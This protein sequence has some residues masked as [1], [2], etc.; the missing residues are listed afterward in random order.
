MSLPVILAAFVLRKR[1]ILHESDSR[2]GLANRIASKFAS[3]VCVAFP[4]LQ[5]RGKKYRLTGNPVRPEVADGKAE[6]GYKITGFKK[7]KPVLLVWGGSQGAAQINK[8]IEADFDR[9]TKHFQVIHITGAGKSI[10]KGSLHY[11]HFEYLGEE[12]KHV[13]VITDL[14][15]GR[16]GANS[17]YE[18]AYLKKPHIMIPLGNADQLGNAHYF[19]SEKAGITFKEGQNLFDLARELWQDK[20]LQ[21]EMKKALGKISG[22]GANEEI[23]K[24]ILGL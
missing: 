2:M 12:L 20:A 24:I 19:Q 23:V 9:F 8:L 7:D 4:Q 16:A 3:V 18:L 21:S 13:Y 22:K 1:V 17:L 6:E 14:V 5:S 15:I 10:A 11:A